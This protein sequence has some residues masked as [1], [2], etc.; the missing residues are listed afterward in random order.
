MNRTESPLS[1]ALRLVEAGL[2]Q[3]GRFAQ[4]DN[5]IWPVQVRLSWLPSYPDLLREVAAALAA[6]LDGLPA[7]RLLT[8]PE[9]IP[10]GTALSLHTGLPMTYAPVTARNRP[11]ALVIEGAYDVGHPTV[12]LA[13]I[14]TDAEQA[15][16]LIELARHVG[17]DVSSVLVAFDV[18]RGAHR[19][20]HAA[21]YQVRCL[22]TLSDLLAPFVERGLITDSLR[23]TI[24]RW[25]VNPPAPAN[26]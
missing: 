21:G 19:Q 23:A 7:D 2:I 14:L 1:L 5:S 10:L 26:L 17:L 11:A 20:L 15:R 3:F 4:L 22:L 13:D 12:L 25:L 8:T 9:A 16:Q 18:G 24:Q 6:L